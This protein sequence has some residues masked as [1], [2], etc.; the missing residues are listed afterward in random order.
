MDIYVKVA[1]IQMS[2]LDNEFLYIRNSVSYV[3]TT[4][5]HCN[6]DVMI[7]YSVTPLLH[8]H[9][10]Y[11]KKGLHTYIKYTHTNTPNYTQMVYGHVYS[12][13]TYVPKIDNNGLCTCIQYTHT[14]GPKSEQKWS[15]YVYIKHTQP[16]QTNQ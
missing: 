2:C 11:E 7:K 16:P 9:R 6:N 4:E 8:T 5:V 14:Q 3:N 13:H 15:T 10:P 1:Y 12:T